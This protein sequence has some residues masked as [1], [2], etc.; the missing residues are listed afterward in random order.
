[1]NR[2]V[3][4]ALPAG[5]AFVE[6]LRRA[7]DDDDAVAPIDLRLPPSA[8]T[9]LLDALSPSVVVEPGAIHE[10]PD[11][12][13][14]EPGD[15]LVMTTSGTTGEPKGVVLTHDAIMA[16]ALATS[17]RLAVDP[18]AD[19]WLAC[20]PLAHIGGL[21]VV[22]RALVT[23]TPFTVQPSFDPAAVELA[24]REGATL[25]S[26]VPTMLA[27]TDVSSFRQVVLGGASLP[28][29]RPPNTVASYGMTETGSGMVYED[30]PLDGVE[31]R[32]DNG[33]I[34]VRG[35]ILLR[36]YRDGTDPKDADGWF[37]TGDGGSLES[38]HLEVHGRIGDMIISG[39]ENVW[40][41]PVEALLAVHPG[42]AEVAVVGRSDPEWGQRVTAV[43]VPCGRPDLSLEELRDLVK[44][45]LPAYCAPHSIEYVTELTRTPIGKIR[46]EAL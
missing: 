15:A 2:L 33:E 12:R 16:S 14:V 18:L 3:A 25:V 45:E 31:I 23:G 28:P 26:M 44:A 30:E 24:A 10:R 39:G 46:R 32:V 38:G 5:P 42:I 7:W 40:P 19:S 37:A 11:G 29:R 4:L 35:P 8:R 36:C 9:R 13:P 21:S 17:A 41:A 6:A 34:Q 43:V 27:R 20:M 1:V 22:C